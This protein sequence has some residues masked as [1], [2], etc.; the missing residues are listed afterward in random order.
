MLASLLVLNYCLV[1][2]FYS[3]LWEIISL[4]YGYF[5]WYLI[6]RDRIIFIMNMLNS[7]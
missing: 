1:F 2:V 4:F 6:R 5:I 7:I 3:D